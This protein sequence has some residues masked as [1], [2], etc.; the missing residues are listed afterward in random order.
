MRNIKKI[1]KNKLKKKEETK[2]VPYKIKRI[3]KKFSIPLPEKDIKN[4]AKK[5]TFIT[6]GDILAFLMNRSNE[7]NVLIKQKQKIVTTDFALYEAI[8]STRGSVEVPLEKLKILLWNVIIIPQEKKLLTRE[9][10]NEIRR[11]HG[12]I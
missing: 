5:Y 6:A 4:L 7:L 10:M 3:V 9:R 8:G 11:S 1:I 12:G 2:K